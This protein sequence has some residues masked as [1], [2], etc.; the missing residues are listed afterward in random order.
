M[1]SDLLLLSRSCAFLLHHLGG[2]LLTLDLDLSTAL[3]GRSLLLLLDLLLTTPL[4]D[5]L[6]DLLLTTTLLGLRLGST[7]LR[8]SLR[9]RL[10]L[11]AT[12]AGAL[13]C[14]GGRGGLGLGGL[15]LTLGQ[16][17]RHLGR[18]RG[19][20]RDLALKSWQGG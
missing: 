8:L 20:L 10:L 11:R 16:G 13:L 17:L 1:L 15:L 7:L 19:R 9:L 12:L 14:L 3:L 5:L 4:L 2:L 18:H 6:L